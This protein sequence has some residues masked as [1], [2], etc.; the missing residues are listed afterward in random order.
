MLRISRCLRSAAALFVV[1]FALPALAN[2][3]QQRQLPRRTPNPIQWILRKLF[4]E[5]IAVPKG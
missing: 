1:T 2:L 4:G 3:Q 5:E